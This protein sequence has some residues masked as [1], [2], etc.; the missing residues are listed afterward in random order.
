[1]AGLSPTAACVNTPAAPIASR[2]WTYHEIVDFPLMVR[3]L[4]FSPVATG[5]L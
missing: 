4:R 5:T 2:D 3:T 1:M